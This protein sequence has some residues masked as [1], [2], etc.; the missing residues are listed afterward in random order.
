MFWFQ[1]PILWTI[2][3]HKVNTEIHNRLI[4]LNKIGRKLLDAL[5]RVI[6]E[7]AL[8]CTADVV[9][10]CPNIPHGGG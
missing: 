6:P 5:P 2:T 1:A 8:L 3:T 7:S 9:G 4:N 10:L